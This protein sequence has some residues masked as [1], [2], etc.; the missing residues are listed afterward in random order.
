MA[1]SDYINRK[2]DY[3]ALQNTVGPGE[4]KLGL[5]L[6]N[7]NTS[8]KITTGVQK[9]AQRWLLEFLT[10]TGSIPALP[11][12]GCLF[13]RQARTGRF[14][15]PINIRSAFALADMNIR[16]N[17]QAEETSDMPDDERFADAELLNAAVLPGENVSQNSGT[18][19]VF[20][21]LGVKITSLAGD[22]REIILPINTLP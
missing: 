5:E 18:T 7:E 8:G 4:R 19:A 12:R 16:R 22:S 13:M 9:L 2:Y 14:R 20:L 17:L 10:E 11:D 6:F 1:L 21:T 15:T 3:L